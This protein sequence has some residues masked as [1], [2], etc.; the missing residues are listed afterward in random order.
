MPSYSTPVSRVSC[1]LF[2]RIWRA[3][4]SSCLLSGAPAYRHS[5]R[6]A[7]LRFAILSFALHSTSLSIH[8]QTWNGAGANDLWSN[9]NNWVGGVA[10][11]NV[12]TA[13]VAFGGSTRLTPDMD[14]NWNI[15]SLTFNSGAGAFTLGSTGS[16]TLTIQT[17]G[18]T[19]SSSSTETINNAITLGAVQTWSAASGNLV[20]GGNVANGGFL[21]TI[22]G[23][24]NTSASG[25][26]SRTGGL[27]KSGTGD[28]VLTANNTYTGSTRVSD[29]S[30]FAA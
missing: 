24:S 16:F 27:T 6:R 19:N 11:V 15:L 28:L 22:G 18:I 5:L 9:G 13:A 25:I 29:G 3:F 7:S 1:A 21:L 12:G 4:L 8:A 23:S 10:P 17:G 20:F 14:A 30:L 2:R 26:I